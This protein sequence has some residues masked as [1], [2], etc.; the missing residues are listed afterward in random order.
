M[1]LASLSSQFTWI[2]WGVVVAFLLFTTLLGTSLAG[3]QATMRDFFLGG[4]KLPWY[5]VSGSIIATEISAVTF[6]GVPFVV[7]KDG[8]NF[9]YLQ[10]GVMGSLF[11]RIIVGYLLVPQ[12]YRREIYSPYD[13]MGNQLGQRVR[14]MT[15]AL[16]V[17]GAMLAQSARI[18]L[19]GHIMIVLLGDQI[20]WLTTHLGLSDLA[21][22]MIILGVIAIGWALFGGITTVIWT[23]LTLFLTFLVGAL[24]ALGV[25]AWN[26]EGGLA[27]MFRVGWQAKE[28]G[29]WGKF[30]FFDFSPSPFKDFTIWTAVIAAT[31]GGLFSYG[32]DQLLVQGMFTCRDEKQA[33][34]AIIGSAFGQ[35]VTATVMLVGVG[36]FAYYQAHP[37]SGEALELYEKKG[38]RIFPIFIC[39]VIPVGLKGLVM[40]GALAAAIS[41][42]MGVLTAL[43]QTVMGAFYGPLRRKALAA[44]LGSDEAVE[45]QL[46]SPAEHR[47]NLVLSRGLVLFWGVVLCYLAYLTDYIADKEPSILQLALAAAGYAGGALLACFALAFLPFKVDGRGYMWSAPLSVLWVY[48]LAWHNP[49]SHWVCGIFAVVFPLAWLAWQFVPVGPDAGRRVVPAWLQFLLVILGVVGMLLINWYVYA[50]N[51]DNPAKPLTVAWPWY[52]PLGSVVAVTWGYLLARRRA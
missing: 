35:V 31:W 40:A 13:Y 28:S 18:Y 37:L 10:L 42:V 52:A 34:K 32:T 7:F 45:A 11:A 41:T 16:F 26:L 43:S 2:D 49:A 9:T 50:P 17:L 27:E 19:T 39:Q 20:H 5:A 21:W 24:V 30:T 15:S 12:Y 38:D 36:L 14:T 25:A 47:L 22:A 6:I 46:H 4:R 51:P 3:K 48:A 33:R 8:G 23:N 44:R 1:L 29:P